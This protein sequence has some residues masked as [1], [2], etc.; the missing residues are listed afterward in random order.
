MDLKLFVH[1]DDDVRLARRIRR[2]IT[3]RGRDVIGVLKQ[4]HKTVKPSYDEFVLPTMKHADLI[5]QGNETNK[6]AINF[7]VENLGKKLAEM[8][9][10]KRKIERNQ[11]IENSKF[12]HNVNVKMEEKLF[13]SLLQKL[14]NEKEFEEMYLVYFIKKLKEYYYLSSSSEDKDGTLNLNNSK[15]SLLESITMMSPAKHN[16]VK[17]EVNRIVLFISSLLTEKEIE[18]AVDQVETIDPKYIF[19]DIVTLFA[20]PTYVIETLKPKIGRDDISI[21]VYSIG[22]SPELQDFEVNKE[23]AN[24]IFLSEFDN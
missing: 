12:V 23:L 15:I 20:N 13:D 19:I 5:L 8:G 11:I 3:E 18:Y 17:S 9:I 1:E 10:T 6:N 4:W 24:K 16:L 7:I 22:S 21:Q 2:D 14:I